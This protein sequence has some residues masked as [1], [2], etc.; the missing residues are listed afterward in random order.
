[1][2]DHRGHRERGEYIDASLKFV[3]R[4][5]FLLMEINEFLLCICLCALC[6]LCVLCVHFPKIAYFHQ[7]LIQVGG[8]CQMLTFFPSLKS[9]DL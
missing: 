7:A 3:F 2:I 6:V 5:A 1:M 8:S 9:R 4:L